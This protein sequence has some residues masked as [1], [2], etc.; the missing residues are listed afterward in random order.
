MS[1]RTNNSELSGN[2]EYSLSVAQKAS[3]QTTARSLI[4]ALQSSLASV[5][6]RSAGLANVMP[7]AT[8]GHRLWPNQ[9][10]RCCMS[11]FLSWLSLWPNM[12]VPW[13]VPEC[14][15]DQTSLKLRMW[16]R[17]NWPAPNLRVSLLFTGKNGNRD[18][19]GW[20]WRKVNSLSTHH[21]Q[22]K[23]Y[24]VS[25]LKLIWTFFCL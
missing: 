11:P 12:K 1:R 7:L 22:G 9:N 4:K 17:T 5:S 20:V 24:F 3:H 10:S 14:K 15:K 16:C 23:S 25:L 6:L 13:Q 8:W 18:L 2:L 19:R 21:Y